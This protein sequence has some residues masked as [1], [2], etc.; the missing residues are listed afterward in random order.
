MA[1]TEFS[2][3]IRQEA[4]VSKLPALRL[5]LATTSER[6]AGSL[7]QVI[8]GNSLFEF[9][10][11][12]R[13]QPSLAHLTRLT[14]HHSTPG[15]DFFDI[16]SEYSETTVIRTFV[17]IKTDS[18]L[19]AEDMKKEEIEDVL[20]ADSIAAE[21]MKKEEIKDVLNTKNMAA[22]D[23]G[24]EAIS[25][26][27]AEL[28]KEEIKDVLNSTI[29][30]DLNVLNLKISLE[31]IKDDLNLKTLPRYSAI[32]SNKEDS[33]TIKELPIFEN[34]TTHPTIKVSNQF[35]LLPNNIL[36]L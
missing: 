1:Q 29:S 3:Y 28:E 30:E 7:A 21:D 19:V 35:K 18:V 26:L 20:N 31:K 36:A 14:L 5:L 24:K 33:T 4:P 8:P 17:G 22:E 27:V 15:T 10:P 9:V 13:L 34:N 12:S 6:A 23:M 32:H 11:L 2:Y 25:V 16:S